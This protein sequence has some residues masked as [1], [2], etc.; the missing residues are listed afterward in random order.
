MH[1]L[2]CGILS[3]SSTT[4]SLS[5]LHL[6]VGIGQTEACSKK[7]KK[8]KRER[9]GRRPYL[10]SSCGLALAHCALPAQ[11]KIASEKPSPSHGYSTVPTR[12]LIGK[13]A[14][15]MIEK[16]DLHSTLMQPSHTVSTDD[17]SSSD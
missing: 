5:V 3:S 1:A 2:A 6:K 14:G 7:K 13:T 9:R 8:K 4:E 15:S 16:T 11:T 10:I 12:P 17:G